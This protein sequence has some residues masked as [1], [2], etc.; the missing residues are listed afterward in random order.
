MK[1]S[2]PRHNCLCLEEL[3]HKSC[4]A[5]TLPS[6]V[7]SLGRQ[8]IHLQAPSHRSPLRMLDPKPIWGAKVVGWERVAD[9]GCCNS[10]A[11]LR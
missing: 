4:R 8:R 2:K 10:T 7:N 9:V 5:F 6:N 3:L 1:L 11:Q